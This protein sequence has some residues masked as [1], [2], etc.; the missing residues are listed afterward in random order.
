M[1][2]DKVEFIRQATEKMRLLVSHSD[3]ETAH[4]EADHLICIA[5]GAD[6]DYAELISL[7]EEVPKWFA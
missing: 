3:M 2:V 6:E 5:L 4:A 7:Y 1:P